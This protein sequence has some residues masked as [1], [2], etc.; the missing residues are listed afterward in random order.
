MVTS[1]SGRLLPPLVL[2][3]GLPYPGHVRRLVLTEAPFEQWQYEAAGRAIA[4]ALDRAVRVHLIYLLVGKANQTR[5]LYSL[6]SWSIGRANQVKANLNFAIETVLPMSEACAR[7]KN[8]HS[9]FWFCICE[10]KNNQRTRTFFLTDRRGRVWKREPSRDERT[11]APPANQRPESSAATFPRRR[12]RFLSGALPPRTPSEQPLSLIVTFRYGS[13]PNPVIVISVS[14]LG[15]SSLSRL[16]KYRITN[17]K[18]IGSAQTGHTFRPSWPKKPN[19]PQNM[20]LFYFRQ[21]FR[22]NY[23]RQN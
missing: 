13:I 18:V 17:W 15:R 4:M 11:S 1:S 16:S 22:Q 10:R 14:R 21:N 6:D 12:N 19:R 7:P 3:I 5:G 9:A 8:K 20:D 2:A 23:F